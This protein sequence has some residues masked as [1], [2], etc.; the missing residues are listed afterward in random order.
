MVGFSITVLA[1]GVSREEFLNGYIG[2]S[3]ILSTVTLQL[4]FL[5]VVDRVSKWLVSRGNQRDGLYKK[6]DPVD[7][8]GGRTEYELG[9]RH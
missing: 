7:V 4:W 2:S 1:L 5:C 3:W 6:V 8:K 9:N